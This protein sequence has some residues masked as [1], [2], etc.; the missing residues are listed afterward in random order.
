LISTNK[1]YDPDKLKPILIVIEYFG[2][3]FAHLK[4]DKSFKLL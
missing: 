1:R 3:N 2:E 4:L